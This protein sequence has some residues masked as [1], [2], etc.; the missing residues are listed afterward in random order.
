MH[1]NDFRFDLL[2]SLLVTVKRFDI[3]KGQNNTQKHRPTY[4]NRFLSCI[5]ETKRPTKIIIYKNAV[6]SSCLKED[7]IS[8]I[9]ENVFKLAFFTGVVVV[10]DLT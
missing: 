7:K 4:S 8:E 2:T 1:C 6:N 10:S 3:R 5:T 9:K